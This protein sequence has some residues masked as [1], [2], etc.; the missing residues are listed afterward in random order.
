MSDSHTAFDGHV[1]TAAAFSAALTGSA[2]L[3]TIV[4]AQAELSARASDSRSAADWGQLYK[5]QHVL[6]SNAID[7][8]RNQASEAAMWRQRAI[9]AEQRARAAEAAR[10]V[11]ADGIKYLRRAQ[12]V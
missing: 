6:V 2:A 4:A 11:L 10:R 9:D 1:F 3:M 8:A 7:F 12:P 5:R